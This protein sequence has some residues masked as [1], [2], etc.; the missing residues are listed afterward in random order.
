MYILSQKL[1]VLCCF[2]TNYH[3]LSGLKQHKFIILKFPWLKSPDRGY[4][5]SGRVCTGTSKVLTM[6]VVPCEAQSPSQ[7]HSSCW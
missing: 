6:T 1:L 2:I 3:K 7:A 5:S 4:L